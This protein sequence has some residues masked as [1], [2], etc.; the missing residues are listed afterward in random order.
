M[1]TFSRRS[2]IS[3]SLSSLGHLLL[4]QTQP[5]AVTPPIRRHRILFNWDGSMIHCYGRT[6]LKES[7]GPLR[8]SEFVSL[9]FTPIENTAVDTVLFSFGSGNIAEYQSNVL[10]WPGQADNFRFPE[11]KTWHGG[12]AVNASEQYLNPKALA[13]AGCN[14]PA[15]IV[16]ECRKRGLSAFVSLRMNDIHDGQHPRDVL[17]NPELPTFKRQNPDWLVEG[18]DW[19]SAL[20]YEKRP[21]RELKLRVIEEFFDRWDFDGIELDWLRHT[22][23]FRRGTEKENGRYLT[24]FMR[25]VR[26]SLDERSARR[27][28]RIEVAVRVPERVEWCL[29]GGFEVPTWISEG[30]VDMLILGQGLTELPAAMAFRNI[31]KAN[32]LPIYGSIYSYGNGYRVSPD[33]VVR[34][35]AANLWR[36]GADGLYLFNW[37]YY[38]TWRKPLL[39]DIASPTLLPNRNKHYTLVQ[40]FEPTPRQPGAD[41]LR[42]N[43]VYKSAPVPFLLNAGEPVKT[44]DLRVADDFRNMSAKSRTTEL[45]IAM[46]YTTPGDVLSLFINDKV[47]RPEDWDVAAHMA[48]VGYPIQAPPGEGILGLPSDECSNVTFQALR[49]QVPLSMLCQGLNRLSVR[50]KARGESEKPLRVTRIELRVASESNVLV[51]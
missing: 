3:T 4:A 12:I 13:D 51:T 46:E 44:V 20:D 29:E 38:G 34:A 41:Y 35:N 39:N 22:L 31:M 23:D 50:L 32:P 2:L 11:S 8:R 17:P 36:D 37:M 40:R 18:L 16:E 9:V 15:V 26:T 10:E 1:R 30:L 47:L 43:S 48:T 27:G 7:K 5:S 42:Y 14:P 28:R 49:V 25:S 24:Q 6:A 33:E 19:W 21:V 45:W